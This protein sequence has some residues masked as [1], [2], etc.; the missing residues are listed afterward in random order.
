MP[1]QQSVTLPTVDV[2]VKALNKTSATATFKPDKAFAAQI[3]KRLAPYKH[4]PRTFKPALEAVADYVRGEMIVRTF[5]SEGPGWKPLAPRTINERMAQGY[6]GP[7]PVLVRTGDL[8]DELTKKSHPKHVEIIKTGKN[9]RIEIGGSS[10]KFI[11]NQTGKGEGMQRLPRRAMI[12]GTGNVPMSPRD[13]VRIKQ[14]ITK[15]I[16]KHQGRR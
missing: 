1:K 6:G 12:P 15:S 2:E 9:A 8:F 13:H 11:Q 3:T 7:H 4:L 10:Q 16:S 14:I 5:K